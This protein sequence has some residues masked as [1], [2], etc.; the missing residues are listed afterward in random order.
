MPNFCY[1][2]IGDGDHGRML[3]SLVRSARAAGVKEPIHLWTDQA[4]IQL[5]DTHPL[6]KAFDKEHYLFKLRF[7]KDEVSKLNYSH[8]A[9]LDADTWFVRNPGD[10]I[11]RLMSLSPIHVSLESNANN[12]RNRR[13][14]WWGCPLSKYEALM[15]EAGGRSQNVYNCNA[16]FW[17]VHR[18][19]V[20]TVFDLAMHFHGFCSQRGHVFTEEAPLAY[21]MH[22]LCG[23]PELHVLWKTSDVWASDWTGAWKERLPDGKPFLFEDYFTGEKYEVNPAIVHAMRSKELLAC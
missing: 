8:Y 21:A 20:R 23:D 10:I 3:P 5:C 2:S 11:A 14:D 7:L 19:A 16:G 22:M 12:P 15:R 6:E 18:N 4:G 17:I 13:P 1:W 9:F